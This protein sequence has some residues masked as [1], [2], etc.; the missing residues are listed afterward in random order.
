MEGLWQRVGERPHVEGLGREAAADVLLC[1]AILSGRIGSAN[2]IEGAQ[3]IAKDLASESFAAYDALG[4]R[5]K[6]SEALVEVAHCYW[7]EAAFD[8]AR[9]TLRDALGRLTD[10]G[11]LKALALLRLAV[12]ES[13]DGKHAVALSILQEALS[14]AEPLRSHH[15]LGLCHNELAITFKNLYVAEGKS[16][17][18]LDH[19]FIEYTA[20]SYHFEQAGHTRYCARVENNLGF[21]FYHAGRYDEGN[22]HLAR[23]RRL[24]SSMKDAGSVAQVDETRAR[25]LIAQGK[26]T[27]SLKVIKP[28]VAALRNGGENALLA[29]ALTTMGVALARLGRLD[30]SLE[31]FRLAATTAENA[32]DNNSAG[33][34]TLSGIEELHGALRRDELLSLYSR[35]D[36]LLSTCKD[37]D[38]LSRLRAAARIALGPA[39]RSGEA[40]PVSGEGFVHADERTAKL[41]AFAHRAAVTSRPI[42]I[43]GETGT[44]K[45]ALARLI[46]TWS[47]RAGNFIPINCAAISDTLIESQLFGHVRGAFTDAHKD[48]PGA[49][50]EAAGGTLFLDEIGEINEHVQAKLLRL[51]ELG[52]IQP[53]GSSAPAHV[54]VRIIAATNRH[55]RNSLLEGRFRKDLY[56]RLFTFE[57]FLLPLRERPL[58]ALALAR[59]FIAEQTIQ[60]RKAVHF[61]DE[62]VI[63]LSVL[64]L[65]GN[66]RELR[67]IIER[68]ILNAE[69]GD[70]ITAEKLDE[71]R[72]ATLIEPALPESIPP[73]FTLKRAVLEYERRVIELALAQVKGSVSHAATLLGYKHHQT[74]VAMLHMRHKE[75]AGARKPV[76][77]RNKTIFKRPSR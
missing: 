75:L 64:P 41:L 34:A 15:L 22:E 39:D 56:Y 52:E 8:E 38:I 61:T 36:E 9:V 57:M 10:G 4:L 20:A 66:A 27:E 42:V 58:D 69:D 21:L 46:H 14:V 71:F 2:Q 45:E 73:G 31:S 7:R 6:A 30:E 29:E 18:R 55:L 25:V 72:P 17:D 19:A 48:N 49:V 35:A 26:N 11:E 76:I 33:L 5:D 3:E 68:V 54:D 77:P 1:A 51:I 40:S 44:G 24:F 60:Y 50:R 65:Q 16:G 70:V 23:S 12:V 32:G 62:S 28:A 74:F 43:T 13:S 63:G 59:H 37:G 47:G 67:S 53:V